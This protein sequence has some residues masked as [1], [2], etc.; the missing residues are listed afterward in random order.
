MPN[1]PNCQKP[2]YFGKLFF[3]VIC[4]DNCLIVSAE[5]VSSLGKDWHRPCLKCANKACGKTLSAGSHSEV[6]F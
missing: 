4:H 5:R 2:V 1:C 3:Q 6:C